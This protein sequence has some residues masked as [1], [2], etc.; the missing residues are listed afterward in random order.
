MSVRKIRY[1]EPINDCVGVRN[2]N[3]VPYLLESFWFG[4]NIREDLL[5]EV[6]Y[7][8]W[9]GEKEM[10]VNTKGERFMVTGCFI[11]DGERISR[12]KVRLWLSGTIDGAKIFA[13]ADFVLN[14]PDLSWI[15]TFSPVPFGSDGKPKL[16]YSAKELPNILRLMRVVLSG[17]RW[18]LGSFAKAME[19]EVFMVEQIGHILA[20]ANGL[21]LTQHE[22]AFSYKV[23][24]TPSKFET[25]F[26]VKLP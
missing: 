25:V 13:L 21:G 4:S 8:E 6:I 5:L 3:M 11:E 1:Y 26:G 16:P 12:R 24:M 9:T 10:T 19:P 20:I 17:N 18:D 23:V 15:L 2:P 14:R 22:T 7:P